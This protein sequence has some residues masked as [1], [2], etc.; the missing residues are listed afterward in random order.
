MKINEIFYSIQGEGKL[1]GLPTIFIRTTGCNLRCSYCDTTYAYDSGEE[2]EIAD[3]IEKIQN[4][5]GKSICVTGGEPL[6]HEETTP[7]INHLLEKEYII[8]L[9]TNGST[10]IERVSGMK[11]LL[12]SLDI[13]CPSSSMQHKMN[14]RNISYLTTTDQLKFVIQNRDDYEYA[15]KIL[16]KYM[17]KSAIFFQ[18]VWGFDIK[19][20][21]SWVLADGLDVRI[22]FQ[23]HKIIWGDKKGV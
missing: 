19:T 11:N 1:V 16:K 8:T 18:P 21:S 12:L 17:P 22:G 23:L 7:L 9:E 14:F 6:I 4:Y 10:S 5:P 15:K 20:L 3:I 13:K 2:M